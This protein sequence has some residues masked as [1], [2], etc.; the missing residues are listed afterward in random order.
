MRFVKSNVGPGFSLRFRQGIV[1]NQP[2]GP[3]I[4]PFDL[5]CVRASIDRID[6]ID[7]LTN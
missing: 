5:Q 1:A 4:N 6:L 3:E 7:S 2:V